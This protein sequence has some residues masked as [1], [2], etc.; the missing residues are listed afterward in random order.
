MKRIWIVICF[1]TFIVITQASAADDQSL[2][3]SGQEAALRDNIVLTIDDCVDEANVRA[4][5]SLLK[6]RGLRA[7]FFPNTH[8]M[9]KHD[10]QLWRDIVAAGN[11]IGYHTRYHR[12]GLSVKKLAE[13]FATFQDE[14]RQILGDPTYTIRYVRPPDGLWNADWLTWA[15]ANGLYTV[16]WNIVPP[17]EISYLQAVLADEQGGGIL[18]LHPVDNN[19][20][21]LEKNLDTLMQLQN[22][23][24]SPYKITMLS[25]AVND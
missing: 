23:N 11:E 2:I 13:D 19:I 21:W 8:N 10:P 4:I 3:I 9:L 20:R 22:S 5:F 15:S 16:K 6:D 24:G 1:I 7:T 25:N 18:L 14:V 17:V 12:A